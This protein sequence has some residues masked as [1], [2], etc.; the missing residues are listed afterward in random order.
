MAK[1]LQDEARYE[2]AEMKLLEVYKEHPANYEVLYLLG[3]AQTQLKKYLSAQDKLTKAYNIVCKKK[4]RRY[5]DE[6]VDILFALL[7][8]CKQGEDY[9]NMRISL[10]LIYELIKQYGI[11]LDKSGMEYLD[12]CYNFLK[13]MSKQSKR[14]PI[15]SGELMDTQVL[16]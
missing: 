9:E 1:S 11:K 5:R 7:I 16:H 8:A 13:L 2:E 3:Q 15:N 12:E 10:E 14:V 4:D 6:S